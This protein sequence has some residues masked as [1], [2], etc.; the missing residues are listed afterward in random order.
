MINSKISAID[1]PS[2]GSVATY[3][4]RHGGAAFPVLL[5]DPA[6]KHLGMCMTQTGDFFQ[7]KARVMDE[8]RLRLSA[9]RTS[10]CHLYLRK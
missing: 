3:S 9:L 10:G 2:R 8:M 1:Y 7:E 5:P 4:I 6:H